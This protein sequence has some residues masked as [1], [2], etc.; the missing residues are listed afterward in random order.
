MRYF[1][2]LAPRSKSCTWVAVFILLGKKQQPHPRRLRFLR[3]KTFGVD[4]LLDSFDQTMRWVGRL[5]SVQLVH[6]SVLGVLPLC[7]D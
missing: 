1:G 6:K 5:S 3:R 4:P 7:S 2:L